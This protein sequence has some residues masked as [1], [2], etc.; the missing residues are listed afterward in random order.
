MA[1]TIVRIDLSK[2]PPDGAEVF[3]VVFPVFTLSA[4]AIGGLLFA[5]LA[6][7]PD[8]LEVRARGPIPR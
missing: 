1:A 7:A 6:G 8:P 5:L 4:L 3:Y 2:A